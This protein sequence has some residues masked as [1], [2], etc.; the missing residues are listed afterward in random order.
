M[1]AVCRENPRIHDP[2]TS[3]HQRRCRCRRRQAR[4]TA[5]GQAG[6]PVFSRSAG[7]GPPIH[8]GI[9]AAAGDE[10][11]GGSL[12]GTGRDLQ[13]TATHDR[14]GG[15]SGCLQERFLENGGRPGPPGVHSWQERSSTRL[16]PSSPP[17]CQRRH[18]GGLSDRDPRPR[19][20]GPGATA[21]RRGH[22][23][24]R[25]RRATNRPR[26]ESRGSGSAD[27]A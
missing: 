8:H 6:R 9:P 18:A 5:P 26:G 15:G 3:D 7:A 13:D 2:V 22:R 16:C 14:V 24:R 4:R 27:G 12:T 23:W 1:A 20:L 10:T 11:G 19:A 17:L 25:S 21:T